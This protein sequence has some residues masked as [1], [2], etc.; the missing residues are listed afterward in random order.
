[1]CTEAR[2]S[3][4]ATEWWSSSLIRKQGRWSSP[5]CES[6]G[7]PE[8]EGVRI[9]CTK[10]GERGTPLVFMTNGGASPEAATFLK[11]PASKI[12]DKKNGPCSLGSVVMNFF[13]CRLFFWL[14]RSSLPCL[15]GGRS[16]RRL[17]TTCLSQDR[18]SLHG[19]FRRTTQLNDNLLLTCPLFVCFVGVNVSTPFFICLIVLSIF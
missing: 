4:P 10:G 14:L 12:S 6:E 13:R 18:L 1:M 15:R 11:R 16:N 19:C 17:N 5:R 2:A 3:P 8:E 9:S 7:I